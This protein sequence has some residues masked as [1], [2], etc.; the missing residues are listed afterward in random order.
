MV[1]ETLIQDIPTRIYNKLVDS[2]VGSDSVGNIV[3]D[4][5]LSEVEKYGV[6]IQARQSMFVNRANAIKVLVPVSVMVYL[7][8]HLC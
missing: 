1:E 4:L 8:K 3:S 5:F 6:L 2:P 7:L